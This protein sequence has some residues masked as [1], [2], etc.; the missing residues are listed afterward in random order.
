MDVQ[1]IR[2]FKYYYT[3]N[4]DLLWHAFRR[5]RHG[6][7]VQQESKA[8]IYQQ[9]PPVHSLRLSTCII[10]MDSERR[11]APVIAH[12]KTFSDE[13]VVGVDSKTRDNTF[14]VCQ[15]AGADVVFW[16]QND[17]LTCN[18]GLEELV[19]AC[20][21]DWIVRL[22]DDEYLEPSFLRIK[23]ALIAQ[24]YYTHYK[25]PR[26]H[27]CST[28][29]LR[30]INDSYLYPDY[31]MRLFRNDLSLLH[32]PG[33]VGHTAITSSGPKGRVFTTNIIHLNLAIN[34]RQKRE[35]KLER[36]IV[37][38]N[39][40]WVHPINE[41]ALLYEDF[42]YRIQ[43]YDYPDTDFCQLLESVVRMESSSTIVPQAA[44]LAP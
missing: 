16:I 3:L 44:Q 22:D 42:R 32:F 4:K 10:T 36:Y 28:G 20:S 1:P 27:I 37:R 11:I 12:A 31:Q 38:H 39:G 13:V 2:N 14:E 18:G 23:D 17:A 43:P 7:G 29:P 26:L 5:W 35:A 40:G 6:Q 41:Y 9:A 19:K 33:A 25:F 24:D 34:S 30:W 15:Q 21:G 8:G